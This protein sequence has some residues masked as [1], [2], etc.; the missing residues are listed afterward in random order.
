MQS[1]TGFGHAERSWE[2]AEVAVD[3]KT[4]NGRHL[5]LRIRLPRELAA[6]ET[7]LRKLARTQL[8]RGRGEAYVDLSLR[9]SGQYELDE[10]VA[11]SY[12][13]MAEKLASLRVEGKLDVST[14]FQLPGVIKPR[15][16][17]GASQE[18]SQ[19]VLEVFQDAL[20]GVVAVRRAEGENLRV[21]LESRIGALE[22]SVER[23]DAKTAQ[24]Q[25]HY[26]EKLTQR[27][28]ELTQESV[29]D[30]GRM[31]QEVLYYVERSDISEEITR[32]RSHIEHFRKY[33]AASDQASVG[34]NLD[35]LC[36]EMHREMTTVS[37]KSALA[38]IAKIGVEGRVEIE[39]IREQVQNVE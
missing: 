14:L 26:A 31:A 4:V 9:G 11:G 17:K 30:E 6:L 25:N 38:D 16:P 33:L 21:D 23:L 34:K 36:Q 22:R 39:K 29:L 32:L 37:A 27:V 28:R 1:M 18:L 13:S 5:D 2:D 7:D 10:V 3:I 15:Q 24:I 20:A 12:F 8:S 19:V 35:F